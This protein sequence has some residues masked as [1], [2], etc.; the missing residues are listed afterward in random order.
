MKNILILIFVVLCFPFASEANM[1]GDT[2]YYPPIII[3]ANKYAKNYYDIPLSVSSI[4]AHQFQNNIGNGF[5]D[6]LNSVP[7]LMSFTRSGT[8]DVKITIRGFGARGAGDRSNS[9]TSRGVKFLLDGIPESEPDG[10]TSFDNFDM[11]FVQSI[12]VLRS[13]ASSLYGNAA[14]G[15]IAINTY[16]EYSSDYVKF[17]ALAGSFGMQKYALSAFENMRYGGLLGNVS[18]SKYDGYR[19]NSASEK[20]FTNLIF[21]GRISEKTNFTTLITGGYNQFHIPG[22]LTLEEYNSTPEKANRNYLKQQEGRENFTVRIAG[23]IYHSFDAN[24]SISA[25]I[26]ANPKYLERSERKTFRQF[27]RYK[28][29]GALNYKNE[30]SFGNSFRNTLIAGLDEQ[31]Q[32][33]AIL[34]YALNSDASRGALKTNKS[35]GANT[36]GA[37]LQDEIKYKDK[38][39]LLLGMRYDI[40][41]YYSNSFYEAGVDT[42]PPYEAK[43]FKKL[44]PKAAI[45]YNFSDRHSIYAS[46]GTGIEV[47]AGNETSPS[48]E[49]PNLQVNP[50]LQPIISSTVEFGSKQMLSFNRDLQFTMNYDLALFY[51]MV[52][53]ELVPYSGGKFYMSAGKTNRIG[54]EAA[55]NLSLLDMLFLNTSFTYMNSKYSDYVV[56]LGLLNSKDQGKYLNYKDN[57]LAGVPDFFYNISLK[58][59]FEALAYFFAEI[60]L[61]GVSKYKSDDAN[62][63]EVPGY[64]IL[65]LTIGLDEDIQLFDGLKCRVYANL[66]NLLD[67]KYAASSFI[68]PT[69]DK[70][71]KAAYYLEPGLPRNFSVG[72][73][74]KFD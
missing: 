21:K 63:Y 1:K 60:N 64:N 32:D 67:T 50:L 13:N 48:D 25:N 7:G 12:E 56:D 35:E 43:H 33:G 18:Y 24:N 22:P 28:V 23:I 57:S 72:I 46:Y 70:T 11:A 61:R 37:Y 6:A 74:F 20:F 16:P 29:G 73:S 10:R 68:N 39:S 42:L 5:D 2:T 15:V 65:N 4:K 41:S 51:I 17:D 54:G 36:L 66:N 49:Y 55:I 8:P 26:Y 9:G 58:A 52:E 62:L 14:A 69:I 40:V 31:Y 47:P 45:A 44:S 71:T 30:L 3:T 19:E 59:R 53:N 27:T 38:I 34:F